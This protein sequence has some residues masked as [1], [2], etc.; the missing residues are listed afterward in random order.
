MGGCE[1]I[2][3]NFTKKVHYEYNDAIA[4][5]NDE[6]LLLNIVR[7]KYR[8]SPYFIEVNDIAE[9]RKFT[10]RIGPSGSKIGLV[11]N[12]GK[13]E[14]NIVAYSEVFQNPTVRYIPLKG[15]DFTKRMLSPV[16]LAV[17]LGL[18]QAGWNTKRVFN[19]CIECINHL[20][21]ASTASGPTPA[22]KPAYESF[23]EAVN[24][25]DALYSQKRLIIGLN[26]ETRKDLVL[27][28]TNS[29]FQSQKLKSLLGVDSNSSEF[30][31]N[32]NFL[33]TNNT[34]LTVRTRSVMEVLFYLSHAVNVPQK[35]I[36]VGLVTETK[37]ESGE[38]FDWSQYLS[39]E[40]I[41]VDCSEARER[42]QNAFVSIFYRG[43]W[44]Y[45]ADNDL[46]AKSTFMFLNYLFNLQSGNSM[47]SVPALVISTN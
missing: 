29:D 31:F 23:A 44:F 17:V 41:T 39:G 21:N 1:S 32:S 36:D 6:Q 33:D 40:W 35:D 45:I 47:A 11:S 8:E 26:S 46:N 42:P 15:E 43:K 7:L 19:L 22:R 4:K 34:N 9:N 25:M 27:K 18:I 24:L 30:R 28:F 5:T 12:A 16:P 10:T 37:D 13:H 2:G 3:P 14:L 38:I 20:D